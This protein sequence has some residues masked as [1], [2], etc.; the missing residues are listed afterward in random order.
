MSTI[1][2][3]QTYNRKNF[4]TKIMQIFNE[5]IKK[6]KKIFL[7]PN[8]VSYEP[9]PTTTH[10]EILET[11]LKQLSNH[12]VTVGDAPAI[13]AGRSNKIISKSSLKQV[14][15]NY[16][17]RFVNLY[18]E[19]MLTIKSPRGYRIKI[20]NLPLKSDFIISLPVLKTHFT[21][22]LSGALKNQFGYLSKKDRLLMHAKIKNINKG[23]AEV[24]AAVPTNLFIVDAVE[25]MINAQE[26]RHGGCPTKLGYMLAGTDPVALDN[27]SLKLLQ[28]VEPQFEESKQKAMRYIEYAESIGIGSKNHSSTEI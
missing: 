10:P 7:K 17:A 28:E 19:K 13:D 9:Y 14:C 12:E 16:G 4:T 3:S 5:Q 2:S 26:C 23:I 21:V 8:I 11:I 6:A 24:N 25:T 18:S 27:F 22:G 15:D 20:S 1:Y